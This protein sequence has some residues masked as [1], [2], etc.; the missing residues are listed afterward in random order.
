[1]L[2]TICKTNDLMEDGCFNCKGMGECIECC[3]CLEDDLLPICVCGFNISS[4][5]W[6]DCDIKDG[7]H[8]DTE[9]CHMTVCPRCGLKE[10]D[11]GQKD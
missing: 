6:Y 11:C 4:G 10:R 5:D 8:T 7:D 1:M 2:C 3:G 9:G